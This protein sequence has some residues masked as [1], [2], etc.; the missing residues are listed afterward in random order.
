MCVCVVL[1]DE[2]ESMIYIR[3]SFSV[4]FVAWILDSG[5]GAKEVRIV[6]DKERKIKSVVL[7]PFPYF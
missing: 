6:I 3:V 5:F 2:L 7:I 4:F 1:S